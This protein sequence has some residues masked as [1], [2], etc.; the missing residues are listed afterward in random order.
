MSCPYRRDVPAGVW[1]REEYR[2]LRSYD[3]PTAEQ[4]PSVFLC[5]QQDGRLCAGW[6]AVHDMDESLGLRLAL[7]CGAIAPEDVAAIRDYTTEV[8]LF[9]TG[10]AAAMHGLSGVRDPGPLARGMIDRLVRKRATR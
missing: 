8:P 2:K 1:A 3:A 9:A 5:H 7:A 6:V 10:H 4:D